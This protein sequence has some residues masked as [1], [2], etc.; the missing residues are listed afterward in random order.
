MLTAKIEG[1]KFKIEQLREKGAGREA[2]PQLG[3]IARATGLEILRVRSGHELAAGDRR[4]GG[5]L[6]RALRDRLAAAGEPA[7]ATAI[8]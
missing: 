5:E 4:R 1:L 7:A 6:L 2:D 8:A 3:E